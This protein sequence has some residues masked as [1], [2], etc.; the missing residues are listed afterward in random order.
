VVRIPTIASL[1]R[2][3]NFPIYR[4]AS[5]GIKRSKSDTTTTSTANI[6][7]CGNPNFV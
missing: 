3:D 5:N 2:I 1:Q 6:V 7:L 4:S